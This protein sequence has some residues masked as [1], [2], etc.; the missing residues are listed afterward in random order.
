MTALIA[1]A[2][3]SV[4]T[5]CGVWIANRNNFNVV[6][7]Q[8][9]HDAKEKA[10]ERTQGLR[11]LVYLEAVEQ[12]TIANNHLASFSQKDPTKEN[13]TDGFQGFMKAAAK[14]Q[15][16]AEPTT[17]LLV[18]ELVGLYGEL[19][20]RLMARIMPLYEIRSEIEIF[21]DLYTQN[22]V[23]FTR[24]LGKMTDFNESAQINDRVFNA[25][26]RSAE[27]YNEEA[28]KYAAKTQQARA[29]F[30]K[31]NIEL[32]KQLFLEMKDVGEKQM[33]VLI[34][35]RKDLGLSAEL[36]AFCKQLQEQQN[37]FSVQFEIFL[38]EIKKQQV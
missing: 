21:D 9:E 35:I 26:S 33:P 11:R 5:L 22:Q 37:R 30:N 14:L 32:S 29:D 7:I 1:S 28:S 10:I 3:T 18:N 25:L 31:L 13:L 36:D 4:T 16:V 17:A 2:I 38:Q 12:L 27:R 15:L 20:I 8:M 6:R 19:I 23:Q 34:A 24:V